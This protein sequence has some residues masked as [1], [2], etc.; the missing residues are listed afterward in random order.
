MLSDELIADRRA[1]VAREEQ[2]DREE[3]AWLKR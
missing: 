2:K 3:Q 1:E